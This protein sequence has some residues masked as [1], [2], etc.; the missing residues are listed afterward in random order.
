MYVK[1]LYAISIRI[2]LRTTLRIAVEDWETRKVDDTGRWQKSSRQTRRY[3]RRRNA[4]EL[5]LKSTQ[6]PG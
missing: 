5:Y 3:S 2:L 6:F 1:A 4:A